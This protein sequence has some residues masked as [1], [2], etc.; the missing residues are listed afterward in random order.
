M[1]YI[2]VK[3]EE[4]V[5]SYLLDE[6]GHAAEIHAESPADG[7][8]IGDIYIGLVQNVAR[9]INAAFVEILPGLNG[10]LPF[11]EIVEP[12]YTLKGPSDQIQ[13]GDQLV[14]QI[15]RDAFGDKDVSLT[16]RISLHG[17]YAVLTSGGVGLGVSRR[18]P[19]AQRSALKDRVL[20]SDEFADIQKRV[21]PCGIV[22]RT[23]ASLAIA[24]EMEDAGADTESAADGDRPCV[25]DVLDE[26]ADL[27]AKMLDLKLKAPYRSVHSNLL[28]TP[29]RWLDRVLH[30]PEES[31][32]EI[33]TDDL[34][35]YRQIRQALGQTKERYQV[36]YYDDPQ[37]SLT[38]LYSLER[39]LER[40]VCKRVN[41]KS[42]ADLVIE[43]TEALHVIDVN[44]GRIRSSRKKSREESL[45]EVNLEAA[46]EA[47]RQI[48]LRNLSGIIIIDFI[49]LNEAAHSLRI[50]EEL[51]QAA[52]KD[53]VRTQVVDMTKLGLVEM[54]RQKIELP[55]A[56]CIKNDIRPDW[57]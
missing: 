11:D 23:N 57:H 29:P 4:Q 32:E 30:L 3:K 18:I 25:Q 48:R 43:S 20:S 35:L 44:S 26:L 15:S 55:L 16:T 17:R 13:A 52:A 37:V 50:I 36:R 14:V 22:L 7:P 49:N 56:E 8:K 38:N 51:R 41:L 45:L 54:T 34:S 27:E 12:V 5:F 9:N 2:L 6:A 33:I 39:E 28:K 53:P 47:C 40:A 21:G 1:K 19:E 10:Y 42:G 24:S 31:T 46:R